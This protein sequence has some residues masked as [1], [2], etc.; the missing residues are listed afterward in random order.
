MGCLISIIDGQDLPAF[1]AYI[2]HGQDR[3]ITFEWAPDSDFPKDRMPKEKEFAVWD[4]WIK[5]IIDKHFD[6]KIEYK[7][8]EIPEEITPEE[9]EVIIRKMITPFVFEYEHGPF[10]TDDFLKE[11]LDR[12]RSGFSEYEGVD[13]KKWFQDFLSWVMYGGHL[14]AFLAYIEHESDKFPIQEIMISSTP[15]D[16]S[17][18]LVESDSQR[19]GFYKEGGKWRI[20]FEG[21]TYYIDNKKPLDYMLPLIKQ[22]KK[23]FRRIE[24]C[25]IVEGVYRP[26][27]KEKNKKEEED[28]NDEATAYEEGLYLQGAIKKHSEKD[29]QKIKESIHKLYQEYLNDRDGKMTGMEKGKDGT[30]SN[31]LLKLNMAS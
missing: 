27:K 8:S 14:P 10:Q 17:Q 15:N 5:P 6:G 2:D 12:L 22:P 26:Q 23:S 7:Y 18:N 19:R 9:I 29:I 13:L 28:V 3:K 30:K 21:H 4:H 25:Q 1:L 24:L 20:M 11:V 16:T 31:D